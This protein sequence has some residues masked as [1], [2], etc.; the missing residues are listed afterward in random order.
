MKNLTSTAII[1]LLL[2]VGCSKE[3]ETTSTT[4]LNY[5]NEVLSIMEQRSINRSTINWPQVRQETLTRAANAQTM[6]AAEPALMW[7]LRQLGDNHSFIHTSDG[8][9]LWIG[10]LRCEGAITGFI[11]TSELG[12]VRVP[13]FMGSGEQSN[14]YARD[15]QQSIRNQDN[16]N[17]KGWIVDLRGETGGNMWPMIAGIGPILGDGIAGYFIEPDGTEISWG[18]SSGRSLYGGSPVETVTSPY[19]L[20]KPN[21]KVAVLVDNGTASSGEAVLVSFIGRPNTRL[22]G[23]PSCG[24]STANGTFPLSDGSTLYLTVGV[25]ADRSKNKYG[26]AIPPDEVHAGAAA[27]S[28]AVAWIRN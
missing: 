6:R 27:V 12:Y 15:M 28:A 23:T 4:V 24:L 25:F 10:S 11:P 3:N 7:A 16:P 17:M 9:M 8:R 26:Q 20:L 22:F 21:P 19:T 2:I 18:Y 14:R 13:L 1:F 5:V